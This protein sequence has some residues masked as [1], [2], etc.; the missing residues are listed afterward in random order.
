MATILIADDDANMRETARRALV[1]DGHIV[2]VAQDGTEALDHVQSHAAALDLLVSDVDMPG[3]TGIELAAK[4]IAL[5]P[6]L[7]VVLISGHSSGFDGT[8]NL[9]PH[10]CQMLTKPFSLDVLRSTVKKVLAS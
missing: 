3:L 4:A 8:E 9:K 10:L 2:I 1:G 6:S 7:K 5:A